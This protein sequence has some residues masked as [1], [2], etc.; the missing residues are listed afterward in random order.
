MVAIFTGLGAGFERGSG[1]VLGGQ[2]LLGSAAQGRAGVGVSVNATSGNV[3]IARQDEFLV[4][5]GSDASLGQVYNSFGSDV[6]PN[7][8]SDRWWFTRD[9]RVFGRTGAENS[10]SSG[11]Y[12]SSHSPGTLI[13]GRHK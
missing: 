9:W 6:S 12:I 10:V 5:S 2:G 4:G 13:S 7:Y 1:S 3:L 11:R 8:I